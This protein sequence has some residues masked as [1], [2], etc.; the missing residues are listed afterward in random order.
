MTFAGT[1]SASSVV[2]IGEPAAP[3]GAHGLG[4]PFA[5]SL[6]LAPPA[7]VHMLEMKKKQRL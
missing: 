1:G 7:Y 4:D 5:A 6:A 2:G 3:G